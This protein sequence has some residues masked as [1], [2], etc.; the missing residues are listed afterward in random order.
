ML[1]GLF[2]LEKRRFRGDLIVLYNDLIE[3][4]GEVEAGLFSHITRDR[5]RGNR[6]K[7]CQGRFRLDVRKKIFSESSQVLEQAV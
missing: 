2:L 4:C 6:L 7:L 3:G 1:T 5:M